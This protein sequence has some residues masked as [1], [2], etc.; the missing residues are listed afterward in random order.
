VVEV[1]PRLT[2]AYVGLTEALDTNVA[3]A[4]LGVFDQVSHRRRGRSGPV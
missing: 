1:D 4:I 3:A 2:T